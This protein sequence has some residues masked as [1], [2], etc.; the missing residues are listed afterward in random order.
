MKGK[1]ELA[2]FANQTSVTLHPETPSAAAPGL[3][4]GLLPAQPGEVASC[5]QSRVPGGVEMVETLAFSGLKNS[6][7]SQSLSFSPPVALP[8]PTPVS[9]GECAPPGKGIW[10]P[11]L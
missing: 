2:P 10:K 5:Y 3:C 6:S 7:G 9:A 11:G 1:S 8:P 4:D